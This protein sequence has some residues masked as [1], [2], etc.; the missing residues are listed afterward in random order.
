MKCFFVFMAILSV[1]SPQL[2]AFSLSVQIEPICSDPINVSQFEEILSKVRG[3]YFPELENEVIEIKPVKS[4]AYFLLAQPSIKTLIKGIE[5]RSYFIRL[6]FKY[7]NCPPSYDALEAILVHELEHIKD[8]T[9]WNSA[10]ITSHGVRYVSSRQFR[11]EYERSTDKK[12]VKRGLNVGLANYRT[13]IYQWLS[14]KEYEKKR[15]YYL[16]PEELL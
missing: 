10:K 16:T 8:Y 5:K 4:D 3:Q 1:L 13:W 6:N 7:M 9:R 15:F 14:P 11:A 12:V 2:W